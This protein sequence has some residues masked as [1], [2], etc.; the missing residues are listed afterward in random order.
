[1]SRFSNAM[2]IV[3]ALLVPLSKAQEATPK[4]GLAQHPFLYCGEWNFVEPQQTIYLVRDGKVSWTYSIPFSE[5]VYGEEH[6][7]EL[8]DCTRLS[9]GNILF[10]RR[11]GASEV[12]PDKKIIWNYDA[13]PGTEIHSVQAIGKDRVLL[14]Q[15]GVPAKLLLINIKTGRREK[16]LELPTGSNRVHGQFRR[17]RMTKAGTFLA[18]RMGVNKVT[19]YDSAGKQ[20]WSV[21]AESAW[22]AVRL[23]NGNTLIGG[24]QAGYV[25]EVNP[26]G[27]TVWEVTK[28]ELPG[29][30]F[31]NVQEVSRLANGDTV[32]CNWIAGDT[33][34]ADWPGSVQV[35]EVTREKK[36]VWQLRQW[37]D[38]NL[39]PASSIQL[40]D[41]P[42]NPE[43]GD[44]QR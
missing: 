29:I 23:K 10:S 8:G 40:L 11:F 27:K 33:N 14:M 25:R 39:G 43:D 9:N 32:I 20:I 2:V 15:N 28:D 3:A 38:P 6:K 44:L 37:S 21:D 30:H 35:V 36:V 22:S 5:I 31:A 18:A 1:M 4:G 26:E 17:V 34:T 41:E 19:E 13:P 16:E 12:T 7:A 24:D 42:G